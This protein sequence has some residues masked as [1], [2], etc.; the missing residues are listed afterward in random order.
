VAIDAAGDVAVA[1]HHTDYG[2][3]PSTEQ[4]AV[5]LRRAGAGFGET[6]AFAGTAYR[7]PDLVADA[8]GTFTL[9]WG[10]ADERVAR[11]GIFVAER[12][13]GA[14][15]F[16]DAHVVA[17][18]DAY[19]SEPEL[20][21][22][23][24]GDAMISW[25]DGASLRPAGGSWGPPERIHTYGRVTSLLNERGDAAVTW[26]GPSLG[27]LFRP[28]GGAFGPPAGA[29]LV[30]PGGQGR[31]NAAGLDAFGTTMVLQAM[32]Q[33]DRRRRLVGYLRHRHGPFGAAVDVSRM[34][35]WTQDPV[36]ATDQF[37]NGVVVYQRL[38][39][40]TSAT[41][42]DAVDYSAT[43]PAVTALRAVDPGR[44]TFRLSEPAR[45]SL[46]VGR[47]GRGLAR[48][49]ARLAAGRNELQTPPELEAR[50]AR[51]GRYLARL[52]AE[53]AGS[54]SPT[55]ARLRFRVGATTRP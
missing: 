51:P 52:R 2:T 55:V 8:Q 27:G 50:L 9:G 28:A 20:G 17:Q 43:A 41:A 6:Q 13:P 19:D 33:D 40:E 36:I 21:G 5:A 30:S 4:I 25:Q 45:I 26:S 54:H 16:G 23:R 34:G 10:G 47:R 32:D 11:G 3:D 15:A 24:R 1:W 42:L 44:F 49:T 38:D 14:P 12:R 48:V 22:N 35:D 29:P 31:P 7:S 18:T 46:V 39:P 37:G 53:G